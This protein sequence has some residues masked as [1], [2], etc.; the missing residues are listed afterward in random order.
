MLVVPKRFSYAQFRRS[1]KPPLCKGRWA[2]SLILL[3]GVVLVVT[4][5]QFFCFA[6]IQPPLHKGALG[7]CT[8]AFA[9][10]EQNTQVKENSMSL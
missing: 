4:I 1:D 9:V 6:K 10:V 7:A 2:K 3:G 5:P 8:T